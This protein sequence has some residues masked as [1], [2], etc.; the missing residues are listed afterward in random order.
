MPFRQKEGIFL[1]KGK[2]SSNIPIHETLYIGLCLAFVGGFLD[3]YTYL[4]RGGVFA[5]A[6]TGNLVLLGVHMAQ[7]EPAGF[8]VYLAPVFA[9]LLGVLITELFKRKFSPRK[10]VEWQHIVVLIEIAMLFVIGLLPRAVPNAVVNI[11]ISFVCSMQF[12]SFRKTN[13]LPYA[14][15]MCTGNLRSAGE[16]LFTFLET[17]DKEAGKSPCGT[18][19]SFSF[20]WLARRLA[21]CFAAC[22][23]PLPSGYV[24]GCLPPPFL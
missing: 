11:A 24:A 17:R 6:Q 4:L 16:F 2:L 19:R 20:S 18:L 12:N 9:F 22:S 23:A 1:K 13:G 15:T 10:F 21:R 3:A 14:S 5:N 8:L 7:G